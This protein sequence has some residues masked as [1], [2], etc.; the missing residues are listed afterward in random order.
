MSLRSITSSPHSTRLREPIS[1]SPC[2]RTAF[3]FW[4][5]SPCAATASSSL[6]VTR[7]AVSRLRAIWPAFSDVV[8]VCLADEEYMRPLL[9]LAFQY[10]RGPPLRNA[11]STDGLQ[12]LSAVARHSHAPCGPTHSNASARERRPCGTARRARHSRYGCSAR[13]RIGSL[14]VES[15][16]LVRIW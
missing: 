5:P 14:L 13:L 15:C 3:G 12:G 4:F 2:G 7:I 10:S 8:S 16:S 6:S 9:A 1:P 11:Q